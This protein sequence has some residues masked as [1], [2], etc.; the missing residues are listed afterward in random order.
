MQVPAGT[1]YGCKM[2]STV[3]CFD[4][5]CRLLENSSKAVNYFPPHTYLTQLSAIIYNSNTRT[6]VLEQIDLSYKRP[7]TN[8][9]GKHKMN[10]IMGRL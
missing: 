10:L 4:M 9:S 5:K 2:L 1:Y 8:I 3:T 6:Y 7:L